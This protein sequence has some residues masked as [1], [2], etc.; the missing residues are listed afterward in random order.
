M[1]K[2]FFK[3][4]STLLLLPLLFFSS[5]TAHAENHSYD[6]KSPYYNNCASSA[7]TKAT[8][9]L[10]NEKN[11]KIGIV[12]LK[13][14][15]TCKTAWSKITMNS[16]VTS[17]FEANAEI[18]RNTDGKRYSCDSTGGNGRVVAGQTSC[19]T[20][21]VYDLDPRTSYAFGKYYGSNY[22]VWAYTGSY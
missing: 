8:A 13:F 20:P 7:S 2:L 3:V 19:Y 1:K 9:N 12:E 22:N 4:S 18:T 10:I 16:K 17:G 6:G 21:M 11:E 14:S 15:A 5:I